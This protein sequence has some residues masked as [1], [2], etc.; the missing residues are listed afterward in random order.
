MTRPV[1]VCRLVLEATCLSV[2]AGRAQQSFPTGQT[3]APAYEG[4]ERNEDGSFN[5]VFG[6]M[7]RNWEQVLEIPVGPDNTIDPVDRTRGSRRTSCHAAAGSFSR[8]VFRPILVK[9][10]W[11]GR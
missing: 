5:L 1:L 7:N 3:I 6:Y 2:A 8:Y 11:S 9:R 4:W 10:S